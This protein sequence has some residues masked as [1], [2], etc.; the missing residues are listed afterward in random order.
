MTLTYHKKTECQFIVKL[1]ASKS[2]SN[3][4]LILQFLFPEIQI[5]NLSKASDTAIVK[6]CLAAI[7]KG[8]SKID[9]EDAGTAFRF[10]TAL[11]AI[12]EGKW[13]L[14]GTERLQERPISALIDALR[15]LGADIDYLEKPNYA[16]L[17]IKGKSLSGGRL[18]MTANT[19]SQFIT[20]LMLI[21]T[22]LEKGI[23]ID[24]QGDKVSGDYIKMNQKILNELG[25]KVEMTQNQIGVHPNRKIKPQNIFNVESDWSAASYFYAMAVLIPGREIHLPHLYRD[26]AQGDSIIAE[27]MQE[28]GVQTTFDSVGITISGKS[29]QQMDFFEYNFIDCPDLAQ[30]VISICAA[31]NIK[32]RFTGLSTLRNKE[33]DRIV[34]MQTELSKLGHEFNSVDDIFFNLRKRKENALPKVFELNTY[35]DHRMAMA[36]APWAV[37]CDIIIDNQEVVRKS[38]PDFWQELSNLGFEIN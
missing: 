38:F 14:S 19:S 1:P 27:I 4:V 20:A 17:R 35:H 29:K 9:V 28:F 12:T 10:L 18:M 8:D 37:M 26:S 3:R 5:E 16:P 31:L 30:T 25:F 24:I 32:G 2:I 11:L 21:G 15:D 22:S 33:T 7:R 13:E 6:R 23:Q 36:F 34:A